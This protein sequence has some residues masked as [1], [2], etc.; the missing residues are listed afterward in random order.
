MKVRK[1]TET[2]R[3]RSGR[4]CLEA[5]KPLNTRNILVIAPD[6]KVRGE[7]LPLISQHLPI[8][9]VHE[10]TDYPDRGPLVEALSRQPGLCF[11]DMGSN[12]DTAF[13][14]LAE[15]LTAS[16]QTSVVVILSTNDPDLILR[17]LRAGATE[18]LLQ[19]V[20]SE[21]IHPVLERVAQLSGGFGGPN[22][23]GAK[24]LSVMPVKGACGA[25]TIS[26]SL[27]FQWKRLGLKRILLADFDPTAGTISFLWKVKSNYS[28][29]D[30]LTRSGSLDADLWKGMVTSCQG[31]DVLL[32]PENSVDVSHD[33]PDPGPV[34]D[35]V[36][37]VYENVTIDLGGC[38]SQWATRVA[39]ASDEVL[40][41]TTNELPSLRA[42]QRVLQHL[43]RNHVE[44]SKI[45]LVVN[46]YNPEVGLNQEAIETAL[47]TDVYQVIPSDYQAV[48]RA[49]VDGKP[50]VASSNFGKA[51]QQL[52]DRLHGKT[53]ESV[54]TKK[55]KASGW[56]SIFS[57]L[58]SRASNS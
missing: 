49:L 50:I 14:V 5:A 8:A 39:S 31:L 38:Y 19:P 54:E 29:L 44:R 24:V 40:V 42:A 11:L 30:A 23:Q 10:L 7:L 57:A 47:H 48:Q 1:S 22:G 12:R 45:R 41:V 16:A 3:T 6:R 18:F 58:V 35:F 4:L 55:K 9:P 26:S 15:V 51:V 46:R 52:A 32:S 27:A 20:T 21:Q 33:I 13:G 34:I 43:D 37:H 2:G 17:C 36:R 53:K 25:S 28:F 56:G